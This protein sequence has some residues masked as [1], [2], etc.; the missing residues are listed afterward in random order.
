MACPLI[1]MFYDPK[2][3]MIV[4]FG[5][6]KPCGINH[7]RYSI[8]AEQQAI[9]YCLANDRNNKYQIYISRF[10]RQGKHKPAFCCNACSQLAN[11]YQFQDRI[12]T[13]SEEHKII[14][15]MSDNP[16]LSLAY[17]IKNGS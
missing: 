16:G 2:R 15:A 7:N 3:K 8:H 17:K 6:S 9:Y 11:K 1:I 12:Y 13:I 5:S 10:T 14:T 4:D